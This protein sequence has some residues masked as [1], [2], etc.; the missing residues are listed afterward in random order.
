MWL[1]WSL[2]IPRFPFQQVGIAI[3]RDGGVVSGRNIGTLIHWPR[4]QAG[5]FILTECDSHEI[6]ILSRE[7]QIP[8]LLCAGFF[9]SYHVAAF[10]Q[11]VLVRISDHPET[12]RK[13]FYSRQEN[14]IPSVVWTCFQVIHTVVSFD[15]RCICANLVNT[16]MLS[17]GDEIWRVFG[18]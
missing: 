8:I 18:N 14:S 13:G 2:S 1:M 5:N 17:Y 11:K 15:T 4:K 3:I 16:G 6:T 10:H 7:V 12:W 9:L